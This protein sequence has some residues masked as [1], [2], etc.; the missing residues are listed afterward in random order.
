MIGI[1]NHVS[2]MDPFV[3]LR[4]TA[5]TGIA[6]AGIDDLPLIGRVGKAL[7]AVFVA[8][9]GTAEVSSTSRRGG[10][11]Q[12]LRERLERAAHFPLLVIAPEGCCQNGQS[13]TKFQTGAFALCRPVLPILLRYPYKHFNPAWTLGDT[14]WMLMRVLSQVYT[15][16]EVEVM[17]LRYPSME[18]EK[19]PALFASNVQTEMA[20]ALGQGLCLRNLAVFTHSSTPF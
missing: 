9:K 4:L 15:R 7:Q 12:V 20:A 3:L 17:P 6:K 11:I 19:S 5:V 18:E 8:R 10:T 1:F 16:V 13:V 14:S 2:Y